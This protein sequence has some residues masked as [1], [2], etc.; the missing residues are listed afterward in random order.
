MYVSELCTH[1]YIYTYTYIHIYIF[2]YLHIYI[3][4]Y[5]HTYIY[6]CVYAYMYDP[7]YI[8]TCVEAALYPYDE[9][10]SSAPRSPEMNCKQQPAQAG[11]SFQVVCASMMRHGSFHKW[12]SP[13][14]S[15][16]Y[17]ALVIGAPKFLNP[18]H[19]HLSYMT[20]G[21]TVRRGDCSGL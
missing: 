19:F 21:Q 18:P 7:I 15:Q 2:T 4:T 5:I 6:I 12:G 14:Q 3:Y 11:S 8:Y 1:S 17:V 16:Y 20:D 10:N 9:K 13:L